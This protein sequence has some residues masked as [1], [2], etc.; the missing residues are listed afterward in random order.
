MKNF[1]LKVIRDLSPLRHFG[2]IHHLLMP[3]QDSSSRHKPQAFPSDWMSEG[4][5]Y[6]YIQRYAL[7]FLVCTS[8]LVAFLAS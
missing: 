2:L 8:C 1:A 7:S 5:H 4:V 3:Y 6:F